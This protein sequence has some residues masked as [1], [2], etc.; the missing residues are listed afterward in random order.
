LAESGSP[1]AAAKRLVD[2]AIEWGARDNVSAVV[3][4]YS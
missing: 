4:R 2:A 1:E 3:L